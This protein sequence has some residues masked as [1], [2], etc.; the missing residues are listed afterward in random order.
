MCVRTDNKNHSSE[1]NLKTDKFVNSML[2]KMEKMKK[3][4]NNDEQHPEADLDT[5]AVFTSHQRQFVETV[6][7]KWEDFNKSRYYKIL[8]GT[9]Q[10]AHIVSV[11][12]V[13][14]VVSLLYTSS[15]KSSPD[16][17]SS[18]NNS[19]QQPSSIIMITY[20]LAFCSHFGSQFWMT[21][22]SGLSLYFSL[23]RHAF[24][25]VQKVLFPKYFGMNTFLSAVTLIA[26]NHLNYPWNTGKMLQEV[27][28]STCF[29][30]E[31][32]IRMYAVPPLLEL[33][34]AKTEIEKRAGIGQEVGFH[35]PGPLRNCPHYKKLH[36]N[37]RRVHLY[38]ATG[39]II[40]LVC[41]ALHLQYLAYH[42]ISFS[43]CLQ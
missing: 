35:D 27:T 30:L 18:L 28:L 33:I 9:T 32:I 39:N 8:F 7:Q 23:P 10:P 43:N 22:I 1:N 3:I 34:S 42:L 36:K 4:E 6:N 29:L 38:V 24:G 12:T 16:L 21:F 25:R 2:L 37:F 14:S 26:F 19:L 5:L 20:L 15:P 40:A 13:S 17:S 31:L 11:I 41:T